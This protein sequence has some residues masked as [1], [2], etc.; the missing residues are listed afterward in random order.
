M[1]PIEIDEEHVR[2]KH[3]HL[4]LVLDNEK[5]GRYTTRSVESV[6]IGVSPL[7]EAEVAG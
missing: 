1:T 7:F 4:R 2:G 6:S 3:D 5:K